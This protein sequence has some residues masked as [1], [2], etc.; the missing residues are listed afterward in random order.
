MYFPSFLYGLDIDIAT[1]IDYFPPLVYG[2][3]VDIATDIDIVDKCDI[4]VNINVDMDGATLT[5]FIG[6]T[7]KRS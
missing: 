5:G 4:C 7:C 2:I 1:D 3:D 6:A